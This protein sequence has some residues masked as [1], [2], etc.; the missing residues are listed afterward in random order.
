MSPP[1][2]RGSRKLVKEE[3]DGDDLAV[4]RDDEIGSG[5]SGRLARGARHPP[6]PAAI[7]PFLG[8]QSG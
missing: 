3:I 6:D 2:C 5:I 7:A 4:P 1:Q 8:R